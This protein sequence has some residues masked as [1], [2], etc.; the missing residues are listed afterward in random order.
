MSQ[1]FWVI[2]CMDKERLKVKVKVKGSN[3]FVC[4]LFSWLAVLFISHL[5]ADC[6]WIYAYVYWCQRS[7]NCACVCVSVSGSIH[8]KHLHDKVKLIT[9]Y[10]FIHYL[11]PRTWNW[12]IERQEVSMTM[13][14][15]WRKNCDLFS[16]QLFQFALFSLADFVV[17]KV[18]L[19]N[20]YLFLTRT[21]SLSTK[22]NHPAWSLARHFFLPIVVVAALSH[23]NTCEKNLV[24]LLLAKLVALRN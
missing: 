7:F 14:T 21:R 17:D 4:S 10:L 12:N 9:T 15:N 18:K 23:S 6:N 2:L 8:L 20:K 3:C 22:Y 5:V 11:K 1:R 19:L 24:R 13:T 16:F